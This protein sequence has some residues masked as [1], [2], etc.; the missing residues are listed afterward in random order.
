MTL[1]KEKTEEIIAFYLEHGDQKTVDTF[2]ISHE[3][4]GRYKRLFG[5]YGGD[6][7]NMSLLRKIQERYSPGEL[8]AIADGGRVPNMVFDVPKIDFTGERIRFAHITD[9]HIGSVYYVPERMEKIA[10]EVKKEKVDFVVHTGDVTDGMSGRPG[11]VYELTHIGYERQRE[12]AI[13]QLS[14]LGVPLYMIDGNHDRWHIKNA[15]ALIVKDIAAAIPK[16]E[17]IGHDEGNVSLA[18]RALLRLHHGEDGNSYAISYR[19]QK[20]IEAYTGG[21]KPNVLCV[22]HTHKCIHMPNER[23]IIAL[24]GGCIE[25]QSQWMRSKRISAHCGF[26]II[27]VWVAKAGG[28]SKHTATWYPFY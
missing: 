10:E 26:W 27:D 7:Q 25:R 20:I 13:S 19:V 5:Q 24:S 17:F 9:T 11:H 6:I 4:L 28:I 8:E 3:S 23:N 22:G 18:G 21:E 14:M 1:K 16:A 12:Y 15:G 2:G